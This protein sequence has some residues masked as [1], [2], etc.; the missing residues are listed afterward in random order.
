VFDRT[1]FGDVICD[2]LERWYYDPESTFLMILAPP[3][4][5]KS[6]KVSRFLPAWI[7]GQNPN[8]RIIGTSYGQDYANTISI[9]VQRILQSPN[10]QTLF[11]DVGLPG[12][13][14]GTELERRTMAEW[15][16]SGHTGYYVGRG[17][18]G[19]IT[20][21]GADYIIIDD[22]IK[23]RADAESSNNRD[24]VWEWYKSTLRTRL[25]KGGRIALVLTRWHEDDLAGRL[26]EKMIDDPQADR[27]KVVSFPALYEKTE[28]THSRDKRKVGQPLWPS[29]FDMKFLRQTKATLGSYDWESLYQ[30]NPLPPGGTVIKREWL[31]KITDQA[32]DGLYWFRFWDLAVTKKKT[33]DFTASCQGAMDINGVLY[34]RNMIRGKWEWPT[35]R[36]ILV[37]A[38]KSEDI[39]VGVETAATQVGFV[40]DLQQDKGLQ[41]VTVVGYNPEA[42]K[43]T[44]ALPWIA[45]AESGNFVMVKGPWIADFISE[46]EH[47]TGEGDKHDDQVDAVSGVYKMILEGGGGAVADLGD[48]Y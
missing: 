4:H 40:Q 14:R 23:N 8:A 41:G 10:Y 29:V 25:Q 43:K 39:K 3:R 20:G 6:Q 17:T 2:E 22:P 24:L 13:G 44:R 47:F 21:R 46:C 27:W 32:P 33:S 12:P 48:R 45:K 11:P 28:H 1:K 31:T 5:G 35:V 15:Q 19:G 26:L 16:I 38:G 42:D 9:S 36:K 7:F 30:Q 34:A 18:G 37:A